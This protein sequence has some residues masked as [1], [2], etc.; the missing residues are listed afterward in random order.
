MEKLYLLPDSQSY[1]EDF[2][3]EVYS[4]ELQG[5]SGRYRRDKEGATDKVSVRWSLN[6]QD[7]QYFRSFYRT[8]TKNG[9]LPFLM[10]LVGDDGL[11]VQER[12]CYFV[13]GSVSMPTQRGWT[14]TISAQVEA[15]PVAY[16]PLYDQAVID[17]YTAYAGLGGALYDAL[18]ELVNETL[19]EEL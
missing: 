7:Y 10:D 16:D 15:K 2:G 1:A 11:G 17:T 3:N 12:E 18:A 8:A 5:G 9:A 19:P 14:Y 6:P 4:V 13:A